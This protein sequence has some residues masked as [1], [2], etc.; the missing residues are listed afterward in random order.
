MN[1]LELE[2]VPFK[3]V[4]NFRI[5]D[6]INMQRDFLHSREF[7]PDSGAKLRGERLEMRSVTRKQPFQPFLNVHYVRDRNDQRSSASEHARELA[8]RIRRIL[9][10]F[11]SFYAYDSIERSI[12]EGKS[13]VKITGFDLDSLCR[14][15][16]G[17]K[18]APDD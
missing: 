14:E 8:D 7:I 5:T 18:I 1:T 12:S 13:G 16:L 11:E 9:D 6:R 4:A 15:D 3:Q 10:M 2:S 17:I